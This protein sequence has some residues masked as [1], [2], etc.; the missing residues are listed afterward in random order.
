MAK[1]YEVTPAKR[2]VSW[3]MGQAARAGLGNF[4]VLSTVGRRSGQPRLVT[5]APISDDEGEYLVSPYGESGWVRNVR[6]Q[7]RVGMRRG[8]PEKPVELVDVTGQ[9]PDLVRAYYEREAFARRFMDLPDDPSDDDFARFAH[10][11]PVFR[12]VDRT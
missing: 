7:P 8:G 6:A 9:R 2:L 5:V 4:A 11:F 1:Q 12:I 3:V 10:R